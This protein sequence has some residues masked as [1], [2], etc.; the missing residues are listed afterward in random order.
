MRTFDI[1]LDISIGKQL[2][3]TVLVGKYG[4]VE[5]LNQVAGGGLNKT[6]EATCP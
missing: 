2:R 4:S 6:M 3:K 1:K 5:G